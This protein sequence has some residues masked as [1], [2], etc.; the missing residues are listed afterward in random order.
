M[1]ISKS[2]ADRSIILVIATIVAFITPFMGSSI[3]IALPSIGKEFGMNAISLSWVATSY[4]LASAVFLVPFG[5]AADIF[6]RKKIYI[7]GI[8]VYTIASLLCA[9]S[10]SEAMLISFRVLQGLGSAMIFGTGVAILTSAFPQEER[11]KVLGINV[12]FTYLGLSVG[13]FLGGFMTQH[14][15][16]RSIFLSNVPLG[17]FVMVLAAV[18]LKDEWAE[19]KGERFD[20]TG[21]VIYSLSL[22]SVMYG[23][24]E[25]PSI[26]GTILIITGIAGIFGFAVWASRASHPILNISLF[27]GNR[28]FIFSSLAALINYSATSAVGFLLSLYLQYIKG[29]SPGHAGLIM[30]VQPVI[31]ALLSPFAGKLSDRLEPRLVATAG[32]TLSAAGMFL[33]VFLNE[34]TSL[35]FIIISLALLGLGFALFSSP[36]TNAVMSS[37]EKRFYGVASGILGTMRLTGQMFSMGVATLLFALYIGKVQITP[38]YYHLFTVSVRS[39]FLILAIL[40]IGGIFSSL[41]RGKV[42]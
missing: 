28:V 24:S 34:K 38:K 25:L 37:V 8:A 17:L 4:L 3:N 5:R 11:G 33:M 19:A 1:D 26:T 13:P 14:L 30:V 32:M 42:R 29:F 23:F 2:K 16:W 35:S 20:I 40:S 18:K 36:N 10:F 31:M 7:Y 21:S 39:I 9:F 41:A 6:G 27:K 12:A 15:G 22:V